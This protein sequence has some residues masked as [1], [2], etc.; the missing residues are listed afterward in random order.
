[1]CIPGVCDHT[2]SEQFGSALNIRALQ[3]QLEIFKEMGV[4]AIR[5]GHN[6]PAP[7]LLELVI[8][9]AWW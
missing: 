6:P 1:M 7:E 5:N 2:I 9:R 4:N 3:R 8:A